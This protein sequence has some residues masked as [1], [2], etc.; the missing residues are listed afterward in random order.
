MIKFDR[1]DMQRFAVSMVGALALTAATVVAAAAPARTAVQG[2][3]KGQNIR[4][5][6]Q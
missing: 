3:V 5:V 1:T 6:A 2:V 4:F